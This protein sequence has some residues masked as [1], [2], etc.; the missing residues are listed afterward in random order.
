MVACIRTFLYTP[1]CHQGALC[2]AL[3]HEHHVLE[4]RTVGAV[5]ARSRS[6]LGQVRGQV[7]AGEEGRAE[8]EGRLQTS[9]L[10]CRG[11]LGWRLREAQAVTQE[12]RRVP[13][14]AKRSAVVSSS[15]LTRRWTWPWRAAPG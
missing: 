11:H 6:G 8:G 14:D 7:A 15:R 5:P 9:L 13:R 3:L 10:L 2:W 12:S 4:Q 1:T